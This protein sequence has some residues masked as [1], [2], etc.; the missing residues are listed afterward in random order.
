MSKDR[1]AI[2]SSHPEQIRIEWVHGLPPFTLEVFH[3]TGNDAVSETTDL[4][5]YQT[6]KCTQTIGQTSTP[7]RYHLYSVS[8]SNTEWAPGD[9]A[10]YLSDVIGNVAYRLLTKVDSDSPDEPSKLS[11]LKVIRTLLE[12]RRIDGLFDNRQLLGDLVVAPYLTKLLMRKVHC[13]SI[14]ELFN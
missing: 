5:D 9:Y 4:T 13:S 7:L 8:L 11:A 12:E 14:Q 6:I 2:L 3:A 10:I 1:P